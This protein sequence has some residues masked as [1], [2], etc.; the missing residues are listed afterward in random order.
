MSHEIKAFECDTPGCTKY[1]RRK[2]NATRHENSCWKNPALRAC[3]TCKNLLTIPHE[4]EISAYGQLECAKGLTSDGPEDPFK[5][6]SNCDGWEP[7]N[8]AVN[9]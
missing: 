2:A 8:A 4:P 7:K 5:F 9:P 3:K 1:F 6:L